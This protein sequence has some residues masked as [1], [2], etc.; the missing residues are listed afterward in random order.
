MK[1]H[2]KE[3]G[4]TI[5]EVVLVLAIAGLIFMMVFVALPALQRSQRDAQRK[6]DISRAMTEITSYTS[7]NNGSLPAKTDSYWNNTFL[8]N[9]L[10][11]NSDTFADPSG[12][13]YRFSIDTKNGAD[14]TADFDANN[15]VIVVTY[16]ATCNGE[17]VKTNQGSR[18]IAIRMK[19]E[20]GGVTCQSN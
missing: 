20:G 15:P 7:N 8:P 3:K 14:L 11:T 5:I 6:Q 9:Y 16:G 18:K 2:K 4:F 10:T 17:Q 1:I 12:E 19:L 13:S